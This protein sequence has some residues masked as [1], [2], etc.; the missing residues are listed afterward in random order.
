[1]EALR[2]AA[3]AASTVAR[4]PI[5]SKSAKSAPHRATRRIKNA[6][7][8][9]AEAGEYAR[10]LA[11]DPWEFAV[12]ISYLRRLK[13]S[14]S[15]LRW[16]VA[17]QIVD[18]AIETTPLDK[19]ERTFRR[20]QRLVFSKSTCFVLAPAGQERFEQLAAGDDPTRIAERT[21]SIERR[22]VASRRIVDREMPSWDRNRRELLVGARVVK[23]FKLP[24]VAAESILAA[25]EERDWPERLDDPLTLGDAIKS[26]EQLLVAVQLLNRGQR[27][28]YVRFSTEANGHT[29]CW[30][31]SEQPEPQWSGV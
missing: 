2:M 24:A 20:T 31:L 25:F 6:L 10:Q 17:R 13:L 23:R 18:H 21:G 12:E 16:L 26:L 11:T 7:D 4:R 15:D 9:L 19:A 29:V 22:V 14:N 30:E 8:S 27:A 28:P 5:R 1:M 3:T